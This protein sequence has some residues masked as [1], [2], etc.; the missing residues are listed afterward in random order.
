MIYKAE[1]NGEKLSFNSAEKK[2]KAL[3]KQ[4]NLT[5][6]VTPYRYKLED[7]HFL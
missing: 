5:Y 6:Q 3:T 4:I 1:I 7:P 2:F